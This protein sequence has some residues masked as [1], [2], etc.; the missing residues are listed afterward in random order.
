MTEI[1]PSQATAIYII[2]TWPDKDFSD[3]WI[4][5]PEGAKESVRKELTKMGKEGNIPDIYR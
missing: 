3:L 5:L 1:T 4:Q 2:L